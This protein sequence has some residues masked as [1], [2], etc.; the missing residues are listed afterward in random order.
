MAAHERSARLLVGLLAGGAAAHFLIPKLFDAT[1]PRALPGTPRSWT[2]GSAVVELAVAG[3]VAVP[4]TR[5]IGGLLAAGLL[6]AVFPANV[7]MAYDW[8]DRPAPLRNAALARLPV[9]VPLVLWALRV[10][11]QAAPHRQG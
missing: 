7:K 8:R 2:Y 10:S 6:T 11:R 1:I 4:A 3:A 9:Q 5:R